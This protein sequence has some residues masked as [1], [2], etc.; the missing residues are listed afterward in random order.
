MHKKHKNIVSCLKNNLE[1]NTSLNNFFKFNNIKI[2]KYWFLNFH[3]TWINKKIFFPDNIEAI[4]KKY[5][6]TK[7]YF[8]CP[9]GIGIKNKGWHIN[10]LIIEF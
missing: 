2:S 9:I 1:I 10:Y 8:I 5:K 6:N 4:I 3:I 7:K